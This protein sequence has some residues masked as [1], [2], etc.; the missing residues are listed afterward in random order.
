[1]QLL[2][3]KQTAAAVRDRVAKE[4]AAIGGKP[5]V[6]TLVQVGEDPA[7]SV[8][9]RTKAKMSEK[10]GIESRRLHLDEDAA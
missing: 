9:V 2:D 7:S 10:C 4:V 1:M 8:Y 3:G 5:P 6:L